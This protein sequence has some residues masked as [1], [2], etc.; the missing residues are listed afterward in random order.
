[1]QNSSQVPI[2][3]DVA[4]WYGYPALQSGQTKIVTIAQALGTA[5]AY[6]TLQPEHYF[7]FCG[8][9][10]QTNYDS[11]GGVRASASSNAV[12]SQPPTPNAFEV[13]FQRGSSNNYANVKLTQAE[14][15]S[16]GSFSGK[17]NP[18][19]VIYNESETI[20]F[21]FTDLTSLHLL[22]QAGAAV[23]LEIQFW[24][25]GYS[26][27]YSADGLPDSNLRRFMDYFPALGRAFFGPNGRYGPDAGAPRGQLITR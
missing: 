7:L 1:M 21:K 5:N 10:A 16:A 19:P 27:P 8:F 11:T 2:F 26:I 17:Q 20:N 25:I 23:S 22:T 15:C 4:D 12:I 3:S 14:I 24:L 13:E 9:T 18:Y 6:I